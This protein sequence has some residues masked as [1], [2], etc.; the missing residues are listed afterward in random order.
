MDGCDYDA[1]IVGARVAGSSLALELARQGRR[2]VLLD[3]EE[4]PSDTLSTHFMMPFAVQH[5]VRL[6]VLDDVLAAGF[7]K[8]VRTRTYVGACSLEGPIGPPGSF[9]LC[10]RRSV[11]DTLL[12]DRA[13]RA[14]AEFL[15]RTRAEGLV[16][17]GGRVAGVVVSS[18]G[19]RREL[20]GRVVVGADGKHSR[21]AAWVGAE[22][23]RE[24]PAL[25]PV[26]YGY[27]R[28][29][30]PLP[31]TTFE[32]FHGDGRLGLVMPMRRGEDCLALE[33]R[34]DE[35]DAMRSDPQPGFEERFASLP[36]MAPR[37]RRAE[38]EGKIRGARG[39]AIY[40]R[41]PYGDGWALTGDAAY[42]KDPSTGLG[43]G[44]ALAQSSLLA[45]ALGEWLDGGDWDEALG[46]YHA[47]RDEAMLPLYELTLAHTSLADPA[48]ADLA[49]L[50]AAFSL[51]TSA[52][53]LAHG[54]LQRRAEL[55]PA[56]VLSRV[57]AYAPLFAPAPAG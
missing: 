3:K 17:E 30:A 53:L 28:G 31:E 24:V 41:R 5:L 56:D 13:I 27:Y 51:V 1:V 54:A 7:R 35:L 18:G 19:E 20:R 15:P 55:L 45:V 33:L 32:Y 42:L 9:A 44:D 39:I 57:D 16:D 8:V 22:S 52:R 46:R 23:Y 4:F 2:V 11:L 50:E 38:L 48:P 14:G 49:W 12:L 26:Y 37:L 34:P 21:V 43:I 10:P 6:G 25:R 36:G 40:F 29:L 47:R